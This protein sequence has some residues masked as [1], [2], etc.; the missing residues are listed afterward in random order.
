MLAR[1][2]N[3]TEL[4]TR[5]N[6]DK[7]VLIPRFLA[8]STAGDLARV[9]TS[10]PSRR[11]TCGI[12]NVSWSEQTIPKDSELYYQLHSS[13]VHRILGSLLNLSEPDATTRSSCWTCC[14]R[15]NEYINQHRDGDGTIQLLVC[16]ENCAKE[17]GGTLKFRVGAAERSHHLFPGDAVFFKA[18]ELVHWTTPLLASEQVPHPRR[19]VAVARFYFSPLNELSAPTN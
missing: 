13:R 2:P 5:F 7:Y 8:P 10:W 3:I 11:V 1:E 19:V 18:T 9:V 17:N 16:L 15:S 12:E 6:N 14:Y 4:C